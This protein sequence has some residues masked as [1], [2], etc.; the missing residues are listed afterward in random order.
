VGAGDGLWNALGAGFTSASGYNYGALITFKAE[1]AYTASASGGRIEFHTTPNG[2]SGTATLGGSTT[3]RMRIA[4]DGKLFF[5]GVATTNTHTFNIGLGTI[6]TDP[7]FAIA[8]GGRIHYYDGSPPTNGQILIGNTAG[9]NFEKS[10]LTAGA[11]ISITQNS[12]TGTTTI[13]ATGAAA[14]TAIDLPFNTTTN[15]VG[16]GEAAYASANSVVNKAVATTALPNTA[17]VVGIVSAS[18]VVRV[19][20]IA[21]SASFI[22]GLTLAAGQPVYLSKTAGKL[23]NDVIA[24]VTGDVVAELGIIVSYTSGDV[25]DV[26]LQ[27]KSITV[28]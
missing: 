25:A 13:A 24:F 27:P 28:L 10:T 4:N 8:S 3:E 1:E 2:S 22:T 12:I 26:L 6:P 23:T 9:G 11:G 15:S 16:V 21:S 7:A 19:A 14:S 20:G 5:A 17:R 18:G